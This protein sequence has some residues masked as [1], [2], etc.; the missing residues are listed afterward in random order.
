MVDPE[1]TAAMVQA[2]KNAIVDEVERR[3]SFNV[4]AYGKAW[5]GEYDDTLFIVGDAAQKALVAA[6]EARPAL[7][8]QERP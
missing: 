5:T 3:L 8:E 6:F 2:A 7:S 1:V 4:A